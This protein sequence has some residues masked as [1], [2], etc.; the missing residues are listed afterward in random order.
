MG[1]YWMLSLIG[2]A[3]AG[4]VAVVGLIVRVRDRWGSMSNI[5]WWSLV[6]CCLTALWTVVPIVQTITIRQESVRQTYEK[7]QIQYQIDNMTE[8]TDKVKLNEW[9]LRYD[10]WINDINAEKEAFGIFAWHYAMNMD[11]Y[12]IIALV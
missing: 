1:F 12:T 9:I 7:K 5:L 10:D 11:E 6:I 8:T 3:F 2:F 4:V